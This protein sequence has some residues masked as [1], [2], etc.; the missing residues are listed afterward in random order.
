[1]RETIEDIRYILKFYYKERKNVT[2]FVAKNI[3]DVYGLEILTLKTQL[4][5]MD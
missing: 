4:A 3:F 5:L 1:M 2:L